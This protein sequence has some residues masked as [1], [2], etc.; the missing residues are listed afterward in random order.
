MSHAREELF[1]KKTFFSPNFRT[2]STYIVLLVHNLWK[3][4]LFGLIKAFQD[5]KNTEKLMKTEKKIFF[6]NFILPNPNIC[7]STFATETL[8]SGLAIYTYFALAPFFLI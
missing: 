4:A 2:C 5:Y 3:S 7:S 1:K 8:Q 6:D